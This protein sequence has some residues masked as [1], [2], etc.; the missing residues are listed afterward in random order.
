VF[1]IEP[2]YYL[3]VS[4]PRGY[5]NTAVA[6]QA[7]QSVPGARL[8]VVGGL[9]PHPA[10]GQWSEAITGL[11]CVNDATLRWL[12]AN[13]EALIAPAFEDFGLTPVEA[14]V[15]GKP[16]VA[17]RAGGYLDTVAEDVTG[18]FATFACPDEFAA[19]IERLQ[20]RRFNPSVLRAHGSLFGLDRFVGQMRH[21]VADV[22][23]S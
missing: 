2:G 9:P 17:L 22:L 15:F 11:S 4:R 1:G 21:Q 14:A 18:V 23:Q 10:G 20:R 8:V 6:C 19:A 7:V 16:T 3:T 5:K 13:C 12:Y